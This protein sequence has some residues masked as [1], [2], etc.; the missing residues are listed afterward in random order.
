MGTGQ[1]DFVLIDE[2]DFDPAFHVK[3]EEE[4]PKRGRAPKESE[5]K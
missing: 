2:E 4:K 5:E 3:A 1:G